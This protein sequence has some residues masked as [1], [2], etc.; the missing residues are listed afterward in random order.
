MQLAAAK[1]DAVVVST[2]AEAHFLVSSRLVEQNKIRQLLLGFPISPDKFADV[3][4]LAEKV[5]RFQLFIGTCSDAV[6]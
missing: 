4:A 1:T 2:L 3:F 5:E 6:I